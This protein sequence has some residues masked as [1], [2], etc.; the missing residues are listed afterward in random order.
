MSSLHLRAQGHHREVH[1]RGDEAAAWWQK[2][3]IDPIITARALRLEHPIATGPHML[4]VDDV[5]P[6]SAQSTDPVNPKRDRRGDGARRSGRKS[7][8]GEGMIPHGIV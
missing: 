4:P 2:A 8:P 7:K 3:G 6:S 5:D 1:R